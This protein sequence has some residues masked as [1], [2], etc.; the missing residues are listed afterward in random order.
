MFYGCAFT[1][2]DLS[3]FDTSKVT[4]MEYMFSDCELL[5][6]LNL[7]NFYTPVLSKMNSMF[8]GC[9]KLV[10]IN[11]QNAII[12]STTD[13]QDI[14]INS[15]KNLLICLNT[16]TYK[17]LNNSLISHGCAINNCSYNSLNILESIYNDI[18]ITNECILPQYLKEEQKICL[19][20]KYLTENNECENCY[21]K[22]SLCSIESIN[23]NLCIECNEG[24]Y[25]RD[26]YI[27]NNSF[28][29]CFKYP[30]EGYLDKKDFIFKKIY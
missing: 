17:Y 4:T 7:S 25:K 3:I 21:E 13:I 19:N 12:S 14:I 24:Y 22:C 6:S 11:L 15:S 9:K 16:E 28:I 27:F 23:S 8:N 10:Y 30:L 29:D 1:S 5:T 18:I 26:N 20:G 2:L